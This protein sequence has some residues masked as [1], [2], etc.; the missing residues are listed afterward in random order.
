MEANPATLSEV[1]QRAAKLVRETETWYEGYHW[2]V[3]DAYEI[4]LVASK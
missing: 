3:P 1:R 4:D 2:G